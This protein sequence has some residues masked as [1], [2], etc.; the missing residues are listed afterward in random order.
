MPVSLQ[1]PK[2]Y[3]IEGPEPFSLALVA[4]AI[5]TTACKNKHLKCSS[6][7]RSPVQIFKTLNGFCSQSGQTTPLCVSNPPGSSLYYHN[8]KLT[9]NLVTEFLKN[10]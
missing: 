9:C 10:T 7:A 4:V 3:V 8:N 6:T 5:T 1:Q 2:K